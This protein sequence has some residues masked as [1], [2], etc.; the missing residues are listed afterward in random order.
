MTIPQ[1]TLAVISTGHI[2]QDE[3]Q[4]L[5]E[6]GAQDLNGMQ[7]EEGWM[8]STRRAPEGYACLSYVLGYLKAQGFDWVLFDR[9][10]ECVPDLPTFE[11]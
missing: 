5:T 6:G 4:A 8:L 10:A 9:D 1:E 11:W 2:T 3:A 7:R